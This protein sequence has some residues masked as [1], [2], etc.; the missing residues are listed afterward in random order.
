VLKLCQLV[1]L[2]NRAIVGCTIMFRDVSCIQQC[3]ATVIWYV[4]SQLAAAIV[5]ATYLCFL[6]SFLLQIGLL[7][8]H[9]SDFKVTPLG[10][11]LSLGMSFASWC[12]QQTT[13][14]R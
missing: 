2:Q 14:Q 5:V 6:V 7:L 11:V 9:W 10:Q 1:L 4:Q 12:K 13:V 8:W 3:C